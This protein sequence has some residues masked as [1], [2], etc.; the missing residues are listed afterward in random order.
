MYRL[1]IIIVSILFFSN[2]QAQE[3][4]KAR[5]YV[6]NN[7]NNEKGTV[8]KWLTKTTYAPEGYNIYRKTDKNPQWVKINSAPLK[9]VQGISPGHWGEKEYDDFYT[10]V[11]QVPMEYYQ[12]SIVQALT[13]ISMIKNNSFAEAMGCVWYD[14]EV[15]TGENVQYRITENKGGTE[16]EVIVSEPHTVRIYSKA[17]AVQEVV[18]KRF[19]DRIEF[20]WKHEPQRHYAVKILR[21]DADH[22]WTQISNPPRSIQKIKSDSGLV[23]PSIFY[24]DP[25]SPDTGYTYQFVGIDY[26]GNETEIA[27]F[28]EMPYIDF[29]PPAEPTDISFEVQAKK[30]QI[31]LKWKKVNPE[32]DFVGFNI[33]KMNG[34]TGDTTLVNTSVMLP[35]TAENYTITV[36]E[37]GGYYYAVAALDKSGNRGFANRVFVDLRDIIP[38]SIPRNLTVRS[39]TGKFIFTWMASP[40]KDLKGYIIQ[41]A[42]DGVNNPKFSAINTVPIDS[43]TFVEL[44]SKNVRNKFNYRVI[45]VDTNF[46]RSEPSDIVLAQLPD[47]IAPKQPLIKNAAVVDSSLQ[48]QWIANVDLD[49]AGYHLYKRPSGSETPFEQVN[50]SPI[51]KEAKYFNDKTAEEGIKYEY[52][53]LAFDESGLL[54][55]TSAI[56]T[57]KLPATTGDIK[58]TKVTASAN[59]KKK[60]IALSWQAGKEKADL[61]G[62]TVFRTGSDGM[63]MAASGMLTTTTYVD[64]DVREGESYTYEVRAYSKI[65]DVQ[66]SEQITVEY[67]SK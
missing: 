42:L 51:P 50:F 13:L 59:V 31:D 46:N 52:V 37:P 49:L 11:L 3:A 47:V 38:P 24:V 9:I 17:K 45:A 19:R 18:G 28:V 60:Q 63:P 66:K 34:P 55:D 2:L 6:E 41:K 8:I 56:F 22:D 32:A 14:K 26:F 12:G 39:D 29:F 21:K 67:K 61:L 7:F 44:V 64:K 35:P 10:A 65:G 20:V 40:E 57:G 27:P 36:T 30:M 43:T 15:K 1:L 4:I 23:Y 25:V 33:Y 53:L 48:V 5:I 54:S 62:Y 58:A 16:E